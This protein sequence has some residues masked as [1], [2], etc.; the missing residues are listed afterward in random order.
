MTCT[1][2][3]LYKGKSYPVNEPRKVSASLDKN[4]NLAGSADNGY[5]ITASP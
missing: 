2:N 4:N 5:N 1:G 3:I